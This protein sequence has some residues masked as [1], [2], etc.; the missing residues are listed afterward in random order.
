VSDEA[1]TALG[2]NLAR[3]AMVSSV[4]GVVMP[5]LL[6]VAWYFL[7][8][9]VFFDGAMSPKGHRHLLGALVLNGLAALVVLILVGPFLF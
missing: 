3:R 4:F 1:P 9:V 2:D 5:I 8:R 6:P 7:L